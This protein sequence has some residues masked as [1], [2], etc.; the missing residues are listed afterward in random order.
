MPVFRRGGKVIHPNARLHV[1]RIVTPPAEFLEQ[2]LDAFLKRGIVDCVRL[3]C[4][5]LRLLAQCN[6]RASEANG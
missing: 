4:L 5:L 6:G 1:V 2:G 3:R